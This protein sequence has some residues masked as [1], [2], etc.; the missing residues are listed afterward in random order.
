MTY[1][2]LKS[3]ALGA[4]LITAGFASSAAFANDGHYSNTAMAG[5]QFHHA[6]PVQD[7][8]YQVPLNKNELVRLPAPASAVII[9]DPSIADVSVHSSN[10]LLVIG[11]GY[12]ETN[13]IV[14]DELGNTMMNADIVVGGSRSNGQVRLLKVGEGRQTYSCRPDCN[15][16]PMLGDQVE[17]LDSFGNSS[18]PISNNVV[19]G[20]SQDLGGALGGQII[21]GPNS[22][23]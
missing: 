11:R 22:Q 2:S 15:P 9:A 4:A 1:L 10:T 18:D 6:A 14:L 23:R 17:F 8:L 21:T 7:G 16:A 13:L 3:Y 12:G 5:A 20:P 19:T